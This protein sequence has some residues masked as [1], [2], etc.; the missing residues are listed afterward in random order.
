MN[1]Q[2]IFLE[3]M[4]VDHYDP[5]SVKIAEDFN[6]FNPLKP[7]T[8]TGV[9][10]K[11]TGLA[12]HVY[13]GADELV[14]ELSSGNNPL[15]PLGPIIDWGQEIRSE[16]PSRIYVLNAVVN[17]PYQQFTDPDLEEHFLNQK[18]LIDKLVLNILDM[19][20]MS[21]YSDKHSCSISYGADGTSL[22]NLHFLCN[23]PLDSINT[24]VNNLTLPLYVNKVDLTSYSY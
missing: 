18:G 23:G 3:F 9:L 12:N 21:R 24:L 5:S 4:A 10:E 11:Y 20:F 2:N 13:N 6:T 19:L 7:E 16:N 15:I 1:E 8:L 17:M 22:L 14:L